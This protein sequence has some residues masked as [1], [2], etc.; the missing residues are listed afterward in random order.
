M[1][2]AILA[3]SLLTIFSRACAENKITDSVD[4]IDGEAAHAGHTIQANGNSRIKLEASGITMMEGVS[5]QQAGF[6][7][8]P[9]QGAALVEKK[10]TRKTR[11]VSWEVCGGE[12]ENSTC[13]CKA[14]PGRH[15][16]IRYIRERSVEEQAVHALRGNRYVNWNYRSHARPYNSTPPHEFSKGFKNILHNGKVELHMC[17]GD[18]AGALDC[19]GQHVPDPKPCEFDTNSSNPYDAKA[20]EYCCNGDMHYCSY[21]CVGEE[22]FKCP[23]FTMDINFPG[24]MDPAGG[25]APKR[26]YIADYTDG[27]NPEFETSD[28]VEDAA[29]HVIT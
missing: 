28:E 15:M 10:A 8:R 26:C 21:K 9:S 12:T 11:A 4:V 17:G 13:R 2:S 3:I 7:R 24:G 6:V 27:M 18:H 22:E 1:A 23:E 20:G 19:Y 14:T 25:D 5:L 29:V 16:V